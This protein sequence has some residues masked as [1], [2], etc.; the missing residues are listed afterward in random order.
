MRLPRS[1]KAA[2]ERQTECGGFVE[3]APA[4]PTIARQTRGLQKAEMVRGQSHAGAAIGRDGLDG[5]GSL[6]DEIEHRDARR[7][8]EPGAG[9]SEPSVDV[10]FEFRRIPGGRS[11]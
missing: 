10:A 4:G 9:R 7:I 6:A 3:D 2:P 5:L 1:R 8:G 11:D